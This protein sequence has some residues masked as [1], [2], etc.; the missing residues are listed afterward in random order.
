MIHFLSP[1]WFFLLPLLLLAGWKYR[2]LRLA[3][4]LRAAL[5]AVL[6][7]ALARPVFEKGAGGMDVWVLV[8]RSRS[9]AGLAASGAEEIRAILERS[10]RA[11]DRVRLVDFA[12][13]A[14]ERGYGDP[15]FAE[16]VDATDME[17]ALAYALA[18]MEPTRSNRI[19][20]LTDGWPTTPFEHAAQELARAG[21]PVDYRLVPTRAS[22]D[23]RIESLRTPARVRPG[24]SFILEAELTGP[25]GS[26]ASVPWQIRRGQA[27]PLQ[28]TATLSNGKATI[29]LTDR[30]ASP[31]AAR[32]EMRITPPGDPITENNRAICTLEA[33]GGNSVLLLSGYDDS[34][35]APFLAAQGFT[36]RRPKDPGSLKASDLAGT[37]L[38][39]L[40]NCPAHALPQEFLHALTFFVNDQ[41]GGLLM[42]GGRHSFG[43]GGYFSSPVDELLP[44]SMELKKDKLKLVAALGI[45]LDRSGSM[46]MSVQGGK[47]KM[48]LANSGTCQTI[49]LLSDRDFVSVHAVDSE[50]HLIADIGPVGP[51]R[52]TLLRSVGRIESM[53]GGIFIGTGLKA[54]WEELRHAPAGTRHMI[55][56]ADADDSEEPAD[57]AATLAAMTRENATVSV[58]ALG[59]AKSSDADLLREIARL[60]K[61]RIY[62]CDNPA[63]IPSVFAQ[64]TV[65]VARSTFI[66]ERTALKDTGLWLQIASSLPQWP[67]YVTG[68]NLCYLRE[69]AT[70]AALSADEYR[71][72]LAAFHYR[73]AGRVAAITFAM[74]GQDG[75]AALRWQGYGDMVQTLARWLCRPSPPTGYSLQVDVDGDRLKARLYYG[76][77]RIPEL[78]AR[79][80]RITVESQVE[81]RQETMQGTWERLQP[82]AFACSFPLRRGAIARGAVQLASGVIPFGPVMQHTDP[83]WAMP[84]RA[85]QA[86]L[87]MTARTGGRERLDLPGIW[88]E[89]RSGSEVPL[90][91]P[92][93]WVA[94]ALLVLDALA[95]RAGVLP[96]TT[97][98]PGPESPLDASPAR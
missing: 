6:L 77:E 96:G 46:G 28:G 11:G 30:L 15:V 58:I 3:S 31:G 66:E 20:M 41:G 25:A 8:D 54:G 65:N 89:P 55:L 71:A 87:A 76:D 97:A 51:R 95:T 39:I 4:P 38:V 81:G 79:M 67:E 75:R 22:E 82:G 69:G 7:L 80:P 98:R 44:V 78:A 33:S 9:A 49:S 13:G 50:A 24:E 34:P 14:V 91:L 68:Y 64:E 17:Q 61:G 62:F 35:L 48:D 70:A 36:V 60:G 2:G 47:T 52:E 19:L 21:I 5:L 40:D 53:G 57:Y 12:G 86:F 63:D 26:A 56:F 16:G 72:P 45:V 88:A 85:R 43:S 37:G 27:P 90:R 23:I 18:R 1:E 32:Y 83:E 10:R 74:G 94:L 42:C 93:L 84:Q 92:L 29:R 59:S 73:G